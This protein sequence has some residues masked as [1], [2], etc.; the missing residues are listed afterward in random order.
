MA[1]LLW[2]RINIGGIEVDLTIL[3]LVNQYSLRIN[4][5]G[6]EVLIYAPVQ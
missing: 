3:L 4:I 6:I 1:I 5:G 2:L